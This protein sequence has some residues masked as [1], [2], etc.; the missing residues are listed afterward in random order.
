[1]KTYIPRSKKA[2]RFNSDGTWNKA[3]WK[4]IGGEFGPVG[5]EGDLVQ[6]TKIS[7]DDDR[8]VFEING[9]LKSKTK[10][11]ER[12]EVG[13][14][15]SGRTT[16]VSGEK[17]RS[18]G[19][20][21]ALV[22]PKRMPVLTSAEVKKLLAPV[23]DFQKQT[24]TEQYIDTLP[25]E[26]KEAILAKKAVLGMN[27]EQVVMALGLPRDKL[28]ETKEGVETE[29]WIYG[30]PPGKIEFVTFGNGKVIKIKDSYAGLGG[31]TAPPLKP[32][33]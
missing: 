6:I 21:L 31:S 12:V 4:E 27:R 25:P 28:R 11:Y 23:L 10:W 13:M 2:L 9:G 22:F 19:T 20:T 29:D 7:L 15:G 30:L 33:Q 5:R 24:A 26:I 17:G 3:E 1:M 32:V 8:I 18:A 14:G 16:P